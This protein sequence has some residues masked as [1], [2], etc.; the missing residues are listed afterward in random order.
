[1]QEWHYKTFTDMLKGEDLG[2][3]RYLI[4]YIQQV[5]KE[6]LK[7]LLALARTANSDISVQVYKEGSKPLPAGNR[8]KVTGLDYFT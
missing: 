4:P 8:T 5:T 1:M 2:R 3:N 7:Q 6:E